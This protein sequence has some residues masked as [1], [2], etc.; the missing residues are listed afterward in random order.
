[1]NLP[2]TTSKNQADRE[3]PILL[4]YG[5]SDPQ[6]AALDALSSALFTICF[7]SN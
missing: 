5:R 3:F 1:M 7:G 2:Q 4:H 6:A